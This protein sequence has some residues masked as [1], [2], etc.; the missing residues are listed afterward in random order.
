M[1]ES[2]LLELTP[3][4]SFTRAGYTSRQLAALV[5][6]G[7]LMRLRAGVYADARQWT[8]L[9]QE[10][11]MVARARAW[12]IAAGPEPIFSHA[13]AAAIH[14][15]PV[16]RVDREKV[17][18]VIPDDP[19]K[20]RAAGVVRHR[21]DPLGD[22]VERV[23]G[24]LVTDLAQTVAD[25]AR[26]AAAETSVAAA[27]AALRLIGT[28]PMSEAVDG[29]RNLMST[30]RL[31]V[32]RVGVAK[33]RRVIAFADPRADRPGESISR[34][35]LRRLGFEPP[36]LQV[37]VAGPEGR[38]YIVDF[39]LDDADA[40]GEFDGRV[41][42]VDPAMLAGRTPEQVLLAE[43]QRE[44]WIRGT[45]HRKLARWGMNDLSGAAALGARLAAFSITPP[46]P[47]PGSWGI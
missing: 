42:Y 41:K 40:F 12:R 32:G 31:H 39:A 1:T 29:F 26:T 9:T 34:L 10:Q 4:H 37:A 18:T 25:L 2:P 27:D 14:G 13:T 15:L 28:D 6:R 17:H 38:I 47:A 20:G 33:A 30:Q 43:K 23:D 22:H 7:S 8:R 24:L 3:T 11:R 44:D 19:R 5:E 21:P 35:Y 45:T 36:R 46:H 16:V